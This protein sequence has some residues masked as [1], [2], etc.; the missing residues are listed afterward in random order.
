MHLIKLL[1]Q[2]VFLEEVIK[3]NDREILGFLVWKSER[4]ESQLWIKVRK[5]F[6]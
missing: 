5:L 6:E 4:Y 1:W 3:K 2:N